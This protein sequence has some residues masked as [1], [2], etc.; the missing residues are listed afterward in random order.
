MALGPT[1]GWDSG[2]LGSGDSYRRRLTT[3]GSYTYHDHE[4]TAYTGLVVVEGETLYLP[5][6]I[7]GE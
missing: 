7:R 5:V 2:L 1:D 3:P 4:N 6:V